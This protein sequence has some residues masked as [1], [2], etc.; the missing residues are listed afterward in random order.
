M[1]LEYPPKVS[2]S[3]GKVTG[4]EALVRWQH[5]ARGLVRPDEFIPFAELTGIIGSLTHY[6]LNLALTQVRAWPWADAGICL[7]VA[8][9]ISARN[10]LDDKLVFQIVDL[11]EQHQLTRTCW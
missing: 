9:N 4:V 11:L 7:P 5:P 6:A 1:L 3:T 2:L 8:V 10:L